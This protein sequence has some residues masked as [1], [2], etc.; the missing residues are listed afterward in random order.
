[1]NGVFTFLFTHDPTSQCAYSFEHRCVLFLQILWPFLKQ[2]NPIFHLVCNYTHETTSL[3]FRA[4]ECPMPFHKIWCI[5]S[6]F[7]RCRGTSILIT[8]AVDVYVSEDGNKKDSI[9]VLLQFN[10]GIPHIALNSVKNLQCCESWEIF[11][12]RIQLVLPPFLR[13]HW[14][15]CS[16]LEKLPL[17][18]SVVQLLLVSYESFPSIIL[19]LCRHTLLLSPIVPLDRWVT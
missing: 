18:L 10:M 4:N 13:A 19:Y 1:M 3:R 17:G 2:W 5:L 11:S 6:N 14:K 7:V 15:N 12:T 9:T 16:P 8:C